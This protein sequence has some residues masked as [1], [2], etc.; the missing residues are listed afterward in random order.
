MSK[1]HINIVINVHVDHGADAVQIVLMKILNLPTTDVR[2]LLT[3]SGVC[4]NFGSTMRC[5]QTRYTTNANALKPNV[6]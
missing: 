5:K 6:I 2:I 1:S 4:E 3:T